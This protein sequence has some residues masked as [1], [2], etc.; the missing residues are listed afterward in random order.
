MGFG[1]KTEKAACSGRA[2]VQI[3]IRSCMDDA[4][5]PPPIAVVASAA[6]AAAPSI[7]GARRYSPASPATHA[8]NGSR[9]G[10]R[11]QAGRSRCMPRSSQQAQAGLNRLIADDASR[12]SVSGV[13]R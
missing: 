12:G 9:Q 5:A 3:F 4:S 6:A 1:R 13:R 2:S 10:G 8:C 7:D 11:P